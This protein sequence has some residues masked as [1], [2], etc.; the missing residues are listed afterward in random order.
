MRV[1]EGDLSLAEMDF[2]EAINNRRKH[3]A[4][5]YAMG[6]YYYEQGFD[7]D[8]LRVLSEASDLAPGNAWPYAVIGAIHY[9]DEQFDKALV[10][11]ERAL[12]LGPARWVYSNLGTSYFVESRYAD[13]I[14]T[15]KMA[16]EIAIEM[17][18]EQDI[19][20]TWGNLAAA[21]DAAGNVVPGGEEKAAEC[22]GRAVELA[23]E[24][25]KLAPHD[26][27]LLASLAVYNA[28]LGDSTRAWDYLGKSM[29]LHSGDATVM[30]DIGLTHEILA[31][32]D[33][34]LNWIGRAVENG[35][36]R[37]QVEHT[38]DLRGLCSDVR[39]QRRVQRDGGR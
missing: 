11:W 21:Y 34:A 37:Y 16:I 9:Y 3:W 1:K 8:A 25:L 28:E 14:A 24:E 33:T 15:Y 32:R 7:E 35:F 29:E 18:D 13:A 22:Y 38:P 26:A 10:A 4:P 6:L 17:D 20:V 19:Y 2:K 36:S 39:Y 23:E 12:E 5:Y 31:D 30:F 27:E